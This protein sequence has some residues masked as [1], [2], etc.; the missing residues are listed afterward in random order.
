MYTYAVEVSWFVPTMKTFSNEIS[1]SGIH[2]C[3]YSLMTYHHLYLGLFVILPL[4]IYLTERALGGFALEMLYTGI[5]PMFQI[6][7]IVLQVAVM[8]QGQFLNAMMTE[9]RVYFVLTVSRKNLVNGTL[10]NLKS[11]DE[12]EFKKPLRV[13]HSFFICRC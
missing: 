9:E 5:H 7:F 13:S 6:V 2:V 1:P 8:T 4:D 10:N 12:A 11:V 3:A